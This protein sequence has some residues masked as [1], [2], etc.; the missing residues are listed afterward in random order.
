MVYIHYLQLFLQLA[1][2]SEEAHE[3][4][5]IF[6]VTT[7]TVSYHVLLSFKDVLITYTNEGI[8]LQLMAILHWQNWNFGKYSVS[9][10]LLRSFGSVLTVNLKLNSD[11]WG[12]PMSFCKKSLETTKDFSHLYRVYKILKDC[13]VQ[14][15]YQ[16]R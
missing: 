1:A 9:M 4:D 6:R 8:Y 7:H 11:S 2:N 10:L 15:T 12:S 16:A 5:T 14:K 13:V 3:V